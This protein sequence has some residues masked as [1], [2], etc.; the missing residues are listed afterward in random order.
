MSSESVVTHNISGLCPGCGRSFKKVC[1]YQNRDREVVLYII[2]HDQLELPW[3]CAT[4]TLRFLPD[5]QAVEPPTVRT[6]PV[7]STPESGDSDTI[8]I[9]IDSRSVPECVDR[10]RSLFN[11]LDFNTLD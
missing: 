3:I 1:I 11:T 10:Y 8:Y 9:W 7:P 2:F 6:V 4:P 5:P